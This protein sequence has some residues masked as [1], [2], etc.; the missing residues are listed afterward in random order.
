MTQGTGNDDLA[1]Q[2]ARLR[3]ML[4]ELSVPGT[5]TDGGDTKRVAADRTRTKHAI[6]TTDE[7]VRRSR[8]ELENYDLRCE[9]LPRDLSSGPTWRA[10]LDL[11]I[12]DLESRRLSI[13]DVCLGS[14]AS[15]TTALRCIDLLLAFK[16][17][18]KSPDPYDKR[19]WYLELSSLGRRYMFDYYQAIAARNSDG[20]KSVFSGFRRS[21][22]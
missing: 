4:D 22:G 11:F 5:G 3:Q 21:T 10:L 13:T 1:V 15:T 16:M 8:T 14:R 20:S 9:I 7:L 2:I 12:A 19:R 18:I 6:M 17:V